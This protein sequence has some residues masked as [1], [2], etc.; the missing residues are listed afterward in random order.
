MTTLRSA[1]SRGAF[2]ALLTGSALALSAPA[3]AQ[4]GPAVD[5]QAAEEAGEQGGIQDIVVTARKRN[6]TTQDVPVAVT[7][8]S[9]ATIQKYDLT[10]LE[11]I[12][13]ST[14]SFVV[15]RS[16]SGSGATLVLRGIGSNTTSI[17]LE[18]S[19]A[20]IVEI[21]RAHV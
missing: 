19:V 14:P 17:G 16:P 21:G 15:G 10:S 4:E 11:R 5:G 1:L 8:I 7:A 2:A 12:A 20:V 3:L 6:E 13:A 9:A 18:Q